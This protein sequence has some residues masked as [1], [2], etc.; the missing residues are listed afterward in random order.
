MQLR[1]LAMA[2]L[3][4]VVMMTSGSEASPLGEFQWKNRVLVV[5]ALVGDAAAEAL[6]RST[7]PP[8]QA[9]PSG[10]SS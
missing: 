4:G 7:N 10:R 8:P 2:A 1:Y 3:L 9:C 5:V 6:R